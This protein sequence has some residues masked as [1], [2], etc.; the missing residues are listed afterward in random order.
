MGFYPA[1]CRFATCDGETTDDPD[2][3]YI[4]FLESSNDEPEYATFCLGMMLLHNNYISWKDTES[5]HIEPFKKEGFQ[6]MLKA[7]LKGCKE[8]MYQVALSYFMG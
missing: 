6:I 7:A 5:H 1:L 8:A 2:V 3:M 4:N